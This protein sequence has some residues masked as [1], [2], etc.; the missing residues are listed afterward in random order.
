M[1]KKYVSLKIIIGLLMFALL[2]GCKIPY[3]PPL[4]ATA[5]NNLVVEGYIDGAAPTTIKLSRTRPLSVGDTAA[6]RYETGA[7]VSIED[8]HQNQYPL[9]ETANG[10]YVSF[11]IL[12]L[13]PGNQYRV[14]IV[15]RDGKAYV[16]DFVPFKQSPP[17]DAVSFKLKDNGAQVFVNTHD[18]NNA[19]KYYRWEYNETWEIHSFYSSNLKY[20]EPSFSVIPRT[21]QVRICWRYAK[22][23]T[24]LLAS[25]AKL[26]S[27]VVHEMPL[28]YIQPHDSRLSVLY[29][30][31]VTQYALD[32]DAY[33]YWEAMKSNTENVGSIFDPQPN[34]TRGNVHNA[35]DASEVIVGYIGAGNSFTTRVF[36]PNSDLPS[37]WNPR[38]F[39]DTYPVLNDKDTLIYYYV[40][41]DLSPISEMILNS[42]QKAYLSSTVKCVDCTIFGT[43]VKPPFW[44]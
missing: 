6:F 30:I 9:A 32:I 13:N 40:N 12:S 14:N 1:M 11:G 8:D 18:Q 19:T 5:T 17:I 25:S 37:D 27:D 7:V 2:A 3:D 36:I 4:K 15:T 38:E 21:E 43:N 44:P 42:G 16:S 22:F 39:C 24:I 31:L 29:S 41:G 28:V 33:N 10:A 23:N 20:D 34:Q 35:A 26:S